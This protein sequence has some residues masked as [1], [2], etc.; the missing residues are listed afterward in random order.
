MTTPIVKSLLDEQLD[1]LPSDRI[2]LAFT[3]HTLTG[4]LSQAY[5]AGIEN[6]HAFSRRYC[7]CGEWTV[8][9]EVRA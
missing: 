5:D 8:A 9:Y 6:V 3:H 1:E 7:L 4:A 2:I